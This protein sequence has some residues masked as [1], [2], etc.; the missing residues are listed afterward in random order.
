VT[1]EKNHVAFLTLGVVGQ[2][3][4]IAWRREGVAIN[5]GIVKT[6]FPVD[7]MNQMGTVYPTIGAFV[8]GSATIGSAQPALGYPNHAIAQGTWRSL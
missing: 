8:F 3:D 7:R 5:V 4:E 6:G 1:R 2:L